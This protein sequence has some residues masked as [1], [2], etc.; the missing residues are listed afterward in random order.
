MMYESEIRD[1][2]VAQLACLEPDL[3]HVEKN[4]YIPSDIATRSFIDILARDSADHLVIIELKRSDSAAREAIH[5][6]L[7]YVEA[8]K[9]H[10]AVRD[11]EIRTMIVSTEWDELL[12]PFSR[13]CSDTSLDVTGFLLD[14]SD[15]SKLASDTV[16]PLPIM[17][18]RAFAPV[19]ELNLYTDMDNLRRGVETYER[20]NDSKGL[21]DYVLVILEPPPDHHDSALAFTRAALSDVKR[22]LGEAPDLDEI[23]AQLQTQP[24]Y[25]LMI[26]F[27]PCVLSKEVCID[28]LRRASDE[29]ADEA[30]EYAE[31]LGGM[32][33][34]WQLHES[35]F[36][37]TPTPFRQHLEIGEPAKFRTKL[38]EDEGWSI[39]E[40]KRYGAIAR[41]PLLTDETIVSE[42]GGDTGISRQT[43]DRRISTAVR[44]ELA[45][46]RSEIAEC[47]SDNPVWKANI[48]A[49]LQEVEDDY[50][51]TLLDVHVFSPSTGLYTLYLALTNQPGE[52]YA[53]SYYIKFKNDDDA[54][55]IFFGQLEVNATK[56]TFRDVVDRFYGGDT[57]IL[58]FTA[59]WGCR[60]PRDAEVLDFVGIGY[61][62]YR[63]DTQ[64]D[65]SRFHVWRN[66]AWQEIATAPN[67]EPLARFVERERAF[68]HHLLTKL[69]RRHHPGFVDGSNTDAPLRELAER[70]TLAGTRHEASEFPRHCEICEC[71]FA[72]E[73]FLVKASLPRYG[74]LTASMCADCVQDTGAAVDEHEGKL[75]QRVDADTWERVRF[76]G[77]HMTFA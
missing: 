62:S 67:P 45:T 43:Y 17:A 25:K 30:I 66:N 46:A 23:E 9:S 65:E 15:P 72:E 42:I 27:V 53:P 35:L 69:G 19:H 16:S 71:A 5:E 75:Y 64:G 18:G 48:L 8:V 49:H 36:D 28:A 41:N 39:A 1:L 22:T 4:Q 11:D 56:T 74:D 54:E 70:S 26:Y 6:V 55:I 12:L 44:S 37:A 59:T 47:L 24:E 57:G 50:P 76:G 32:N 29:D 77:S 61:A 13:F 58:A 14:V 73:N 40:I 3:R 10:L 33:E 2:L 20:A 38:L 51:G 21:R 52:R 7:K 31:Y 60:E 34:L 63:C 68:V